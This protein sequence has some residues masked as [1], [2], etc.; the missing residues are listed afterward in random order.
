MKK[1]SSLEYNSL[2]FFV[3]RASFMGLAL[4]NIINI[5]KQDSWI[6]G[7]ISLFLGLIPLTIFIYLKNYDKDK[8]IAELVLSLF[9]K[10]GILINIIMIT[11]G[12]LFALVSFSNLTNFVNSQFLFN[13]NHIIVAICFIIPIIYALAKGIN[14]I[15]KTSLLTFFIVLF[16]IITLIIGVFDGIDLE[17]LKPYLRANTLNIIHS[18]AIIIAFNI[19]PLFLLT[20]I[21]TNKI[22]NYSTKK[23]IVFYI[24]TLLS[25]INAIFL[26]LSVLGTDL[27]LL[28]Q[29]PEFNIL[30]KFEVGDFIDRIESIFS[31]EWVIALIIQIIIA[32]YFVEKTIK[33]TFKTN[34]KTS[35]LIIIASC[36]ILIILNEKLFITNATA[37]V[38]YN[39]PMVIIM[40]SYIFLA[41]IIA[42]KAYLKK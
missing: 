13:T 28:Y 3:M 4:G 24:I 32:L 1:I 5:T 20:I 35:K 17:R 16:I 22:E 15:S 40:L 10:S 12:F 21:P 42:I 23:T 27:A 6:P 7:L 11:G 9:K 41:F 26:V 33:T 2:I 18:S 31:L 25:I 19:V 36:F 29:Y 30:K 38:F 39:G 34:E 14:P 37:N 8:N